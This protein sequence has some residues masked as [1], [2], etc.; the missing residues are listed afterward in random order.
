MKS[1]VGSMVCD[2]AVASKYELLDE[3]VPAAAT[4]HLDHVHLKF[5]KCLLKQRQLGT[6]PGLPRGGL[7]LVAV[8]VVNVRQILA[9]T[10]WAAVLRRV[11][12]KPGCTH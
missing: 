2:D 12:V 6:G 9:P 7:Q 3:V 1:S 11:A 8:Y 4:T 5:A 10:D